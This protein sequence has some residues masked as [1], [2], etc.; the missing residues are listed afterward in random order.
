MASLSPSHS[1]RRLADYPHWLSAFA[2]FICRVTGWRV[3]G[4]L[5]NL[6]QFVV[7]G[8]PHTSNWDGIL[9]LLLSMSLNVRM[10]FLGKH[11]LFRPPFGWLIRLLGGIPINRQTSIN[12]VDEVVERFRE[13]PR[14]VL[15]LAPEGTRR[16]VRRWKTGFYYIALEAG[17]PIVMGY[18]DYSAKRTGLGPLFTPTGDY[19]AD[20]RTILAFY[21]DKQGRHPERMS[22]VQS[23]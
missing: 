13:H 12:A 7:I 11:T 1:V 21:A 9:M 15:V 22:E 18:V 14:M 2:R 17:I 16:K 10:L 23:A 4:E 6:D 19:E 3:E 20:M 5:P 8:A